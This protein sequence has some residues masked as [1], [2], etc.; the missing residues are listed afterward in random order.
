MH[1][2][3][4]AQPT[5][6]PL[7]ESEELRKTVCGARKR[8]RAQTQK[9]AWMSPLYLRHRSTGNVAG[10]EQGSPCRVRVC[11]NR[12]ERRGLAPCSWGVQPWSDVRTCQALHLDSLSLMCGTHLSP[13]PGGREFKFRLGYKVER[14]LENE[15]WGQRGGCSAQERF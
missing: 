6:I 9:T 11:R 3:P 5:G 15:V 7:N 8:G 2:L 13:S 4:A 10:R 12:S 14:A 1:K